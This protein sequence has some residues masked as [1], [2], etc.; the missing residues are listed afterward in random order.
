MDPRPRRRVRQPPGLGGQYH[1]PLAKPPN[2]ISPTR[3]MM[4]PIQKLHTIMRTMPTMTRM[5]PSPIPPRCRPFRVLPPSRLLCSVLH[6]WS[7]THPVHLECSLEGAACI[8][9]ADKRSPPLRYHGNATACLARPGD[10]ER[11]DLSPNCAAII[12]ARRTSLGPA[13]SC[14]WSATSGSSDSSSSRDRRR[15]TRRAKASIPLAALTTPEAAPA[16]SC[17]TSAAAVIWSSSRCDHDLRY[18]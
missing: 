9:R 6:V 7:R 15:N 14:G 4:S 16:S 2:A 18:R 12:A 5:P 3:A 1:L 13:T 17:R 8:A 10:R 11:R